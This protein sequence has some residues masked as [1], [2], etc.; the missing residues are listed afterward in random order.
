VQAHPNREL[1][2]LLC[3]E[4]G[5]HGSAGGREGGAH[6]V[7]GV[8]HPATGGGDAPFEH[9]IV[10]RQGGGHALAVVLPSLRR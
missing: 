7:A 4:R 1:Q 9:R 10:R 5:S 2:R 3:I 6:A 8:E